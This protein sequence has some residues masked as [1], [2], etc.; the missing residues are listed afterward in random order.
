MKREPDVQL[1]RPGVLAT[2]DT[3]RL[4][5]A[6]GRL[7]AAMQTGQRVAR[8]VTHGDAWWSVLAVTARVHGVELAPEGRLLL[9]PQDDTRT[10]VHVLAQ[11]CE[12][13]GLILRRVRLDSGWWNGLQVPLIALRHDASPLAV[14][15]E[16][17]GHCVSEDDSGRRRRV[18][19]ALAAEL[20]PW[21]W[22]V[23]GGLPERSL[24]ISE[25]FRM[26]L[27]RLRP[28]LPLLLGSA[29]GAGLL[30]LVAPVAAAF[31]I[32]V[33]LP[34][35][36][37]GLMLQIGMALFLAVI[38]A[39]GYGL[40][41][42][43]LALRCSTHVSAWLRIALADRML[44]LP[45]ETSLAQA[46]SS[47]QLRLN[48]LDSY[49]S[50]L[51]RLAATGLISGIL[52]L[53][54]L[55][56]LFW[57]AWPA[58]WIVVGLVLILQFAAWRIG[59]A[60]A[61]AFVDGE[62]LGLNVFA[63]AA[64]LLQNLDVVR[65][66]GA[67]QRGFSRWLDAFAELRMRT[68]AS[69][70]QANRFHPIR[71]LHGALALAGVFGAIWLARGQSL[72][73]G[74]FV[75]FVTAF[76]SASALSLKL[77]GAILE[78]H[79]MSPI[80]E[81]ARAPLEAKPDPRG[82]NRLMSR[83]DSVEMSGVSLR[84]PGKANLAFESV[85]LRVSGN[86][87]LAIVGPSGSGK[88]SVLRA[89][90]GLY[91]VA[92]GQVVVDGTDLRRIDLRHFRASIGAVLQD[93]KVFRATVL[94]NVR[95][96]ADADVPAVWQAL[97]QAGLAAEIRSWPMG[98]HTLIG[99][100]G[101]GLSG[102]QV[103]R[104]LLARALVGKPRLMLL[105]EA[106][107]ALDDASQRVVSTAVA[108][109]EI[110]RIVVAHRIETVRHANEICVMQGGRIVERGRFDILYAQNGLFRQMCMAQGVTP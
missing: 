95:A 14:V 106:T 82:R 22:E 24:S 67:V 80:Q 88:S 30:G 83:I 46:P 33:G 81:I 110:P 68:I 79:A 36:D 93:S 75:A 18:S 39:T 76:S 47:W 1:T 77:A 9:G 13:N 10:V 26:C 4:S 52:L 101:G 49:M 102:G 56:L 6:L 16:S 64:E 43:R 20:E 105:D 32:N 74:A 45:L 17:N 65:A 70:A 92:A 103:Q 31:L 7:H 55:A 27:E 73:S 28:E 12:R 40:L 44:A 89:L 84:Y 23:H 38:A 104:I 109:L 108:A 60:A 42:E 87:F 72:D 98:I 53:G 85:S 2:Q 48:A 100:G 11:V 37:L 71:Q 8:R 5:G 91:P 97:E 19:A 50:T 99:D 78:Y 54:Q 90:L 15:P 21:G 96:F 62:K 58:A 3:A 86:D 61:R 25:L 41:A 57:F 63:L 69:R 66:G 94:D 34:T 51:L 107:S 29:L 35:G 59:R